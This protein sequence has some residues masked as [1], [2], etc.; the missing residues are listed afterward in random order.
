MKRTGTFIVFSLWN[1][2]PLPLILFL[3]FRLCEGYCW[4]F[5]QSRL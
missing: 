4:S 3:R 1:Q 5:V 2:L